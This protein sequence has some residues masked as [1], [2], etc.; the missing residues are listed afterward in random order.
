ME[1]ET[2]RKPYLIDLVEDLDAASSIK[3]ASNAPKKV[4]K[5]LATG[6]DI[7]TESEGPNRFNWEMDSVVSSIKPI[8]KPP[9]ARPGKQMKEKE[10]INTERG[11]PNATDALKEAANSDVSS[12]K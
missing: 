9:L 2:E 11:L 6:V 1:P 10:E 12:I 5:I 4:P 8:C 7:T 3:F